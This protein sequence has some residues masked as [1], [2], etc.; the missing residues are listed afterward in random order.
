M[1]R[2]VEAIVFATP[3]PLLATR[4]RNLLSYAGLLLEPAIVR[5]ERLAFAMA[6]KRNHLVMIDGDTKIYWNV[7]AKAMECAP[8]SIFVLCCYAITPDL[9]HAAFASGLHGLISTKADLEEGARALNQICRG[10]RRMCF[11][12]ASGAKPDSALTPSQRRVLPLAARGFRNAEIAEAL[13]MTEASVKVHV[14]HL[15]RKTGAKDRLELAKAVEWEA[16]QAAAAQQATA[17]PAA[18]APSPLPPFAPIPAPSP[19]PPPSFE[20]VH[21]FD[22]TW[23]FGQLHNSVTILQ[24]E[25]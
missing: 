9:V 15:L 5:P 20:E 4:V 12:G 8:E 18:P 2:T 24:E 7:M 3:R 11:D 23:M 17:T 10:E 21:Q 22:F 1:S 25:L 6:G 16:N 19:A 14:H 13:G